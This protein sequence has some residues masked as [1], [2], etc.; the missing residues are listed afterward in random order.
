MKVVILAGGFGTR[1]SE[2]SHL[3]PKPMVEIGDHP[4]LWHIMK[5][6]S[7]YGFNDFVI[8]LGYKGY[9][10]KEYFANYFLH[11]SDVTFDFTNAN[12]LI[13]HKNVAEQWKVTLVDTGIDTMTGG[14]IKYIA[15]YIDSDTFM[16]TYGDGVSDVNLHKLFAFHQQHGG[17]ATVTAIQPAGRFGALQVAANGDVK[18]FQ[19]KPLGDGGW[20]NAG[21]FVFNKGVFD[22][23]EDSSTLLEKG[24]LERMTADHQ[25]HA[26][27]HQGFWLAMDTLRDKE[28]LEAL[29]K[30][31]QAPWKR[32]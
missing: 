13:V 28:Q 25:L 32:W 17:L 16:V 14:R 15:P 26:F 7:Y 4:I 11:A 23:I 30:T 29:W 20:I 24:P 8:C 2:E 31:G 19:E 9:I 6:Y 12:Q 3:R 5:T 18:R 1:I 21:F 27:K 22:Y 10:I